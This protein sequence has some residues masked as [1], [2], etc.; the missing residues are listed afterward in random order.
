MTRWLIGLAA[1]AALAAQ[2]MAAE[3]SRPNVLFISVDDLHDW[4]GV[5]G[6]RPDVKTPNID[7]LAKQGVVFTRAYCAAPACNPSR[8]ALMTGLRPSSTGVYHNDQPWRPVLKDAV[9]LQ[10]YFMKNGYTAEGGGKIYHGRYNE[11]A[12]W[13]HWERAGNSAN[14]T[15]TPVNGIPNTG[16]FDWGP[17]DASDEEMADH[18]TATWAC[19]VLKRKHDKPFFLAPGMIRP[20]LP[21]YA[22]KKYFDMYPLDK[23]EVPKTLSTD[24]EDI[25]PA[26]IRMARP[27]RDHAN[28]VKH[29]Q[30]KKAVQAYLACITFMDAQVGRILDA[31]DKSPYRDNT[32][33]VFWSDHGWHLGEKEHWRKFA[34]WEEATR[35]TLAI[36]VPGVTKPDGVCG[37]TVNLLDLYPTLVELCGL[38]KKDGLEG[39]SLVPLL[40]DP[41][42]KWDRPSITTHGRN[43]HALRTEKWRYIR[44]ADGSEELYDHDADP[45]EWKNLATDPATAK[46]RAELAAQLPKTN[47][48]DA[49]REKDKDNPKKKR[50]KK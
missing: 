5:L 44:Y 46:I 17:V 33:V 20:H 29:D 40:K 14:P 42:A 23:I 9:T 38:P 36:K 45:L 43:N 2:G 49:P 32:I 15:K 28:V 25:P 30:W 6:K 4:V 19:E 7:R 27:D 21:F 50:K 39:A 3:P 34:L 22:P 37:R 24:L 10:E 35:V 16:H 47:V 26:G 31:L 11:P 18:H 13:S 1:L 12:A 41:N 8:A 48:P